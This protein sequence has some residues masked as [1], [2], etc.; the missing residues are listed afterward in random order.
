MIFNKITKAFAI[1]KQFLGILT[2]KFKIRFVF[3]F[4]AI[5]CRRQ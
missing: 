4:I 5:R 2:R 1:I 3:N